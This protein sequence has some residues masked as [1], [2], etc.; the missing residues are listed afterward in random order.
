VLLGR[1]AWLRL[2]LLG[3]AVLR[4]SGRGAAEELAVLA[5]TVRGLAYGVRARRRE[6]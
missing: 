1:W 4:G 6:P 2:V 3:R 5:G